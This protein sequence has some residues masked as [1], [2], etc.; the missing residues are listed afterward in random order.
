M[1]SQAEFEV[2]CIL[3]RLQP[4]L[5]L[6][7][8]HFCDRQ[9]AFAFYQVVVAYY[10]V[11]VVFFKMSS[12]EI[13]NVFDI[14]EESFTRRTRPNPCAEACDFVAQHLV[15]APASERKFRHNHGFLVPSIRK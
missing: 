2:I 1:H 13:H 4:L 12:S 7:G 11:V 3:L 10:Q 8:V 14:F 6:D 5:M 15:W 9:D